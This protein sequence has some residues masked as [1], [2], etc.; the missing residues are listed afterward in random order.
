[1][2]ER[3]IE[4]A[5]ADLFLKQYQRNLVIEIGA[6]LPYYWPHRI[7]TIIDPVDIHPL[8][9]FRE[10]FWNFDLD[11]RPVISISAFEH[12][13]L[14]DYGLVVDEVVPQKAIERLVNTAGDFLVTI[15]FG[16]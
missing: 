16:N 4:L 6:V 9:T 12:I 15:P 3:S 1:M 13:G 14:A 5:L 7:Q 8:V 11:G 10:S 2:T